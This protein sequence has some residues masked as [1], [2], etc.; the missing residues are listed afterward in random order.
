MSPREDWSHIED[1]NE[2]RKAQNRVAQ[3]NYRSRQR[4]RLELAETILLDMS[5]VAAGVDP[6]W[7]GQC[8]IIDPALINGTSVT[9]NGV[10][11]KAYSDFSNSHGGNLA[12]PY[13]NSCTPDLGSQ[14]DKPFSLE[15]VMSLM[16]SFGIEDSPGAGQNGIRKDRDNMAR[17]TSVTSPPVEAA[18]DTCQSRDFGSGR[19]SSSSGCIGGSSNN[20]Q[21]ARAGTFTPSV[22]SPGVTQGGIAKI[23]LLSQPEIEGDDCTPLM[24]AAARG[25]A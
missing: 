1:N 21:T 24:I 14:P 13:L 11:G 17:H 10:P 6:K 20:S 4:R 15:G 18:D 22:E 19:A 8:H 25:N 7:A 5:Q 3:R 2:R 16:D 9:S 12:M 23:D